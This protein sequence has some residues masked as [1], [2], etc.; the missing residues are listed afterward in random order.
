ME[1]ILRVYGYNNV[2]TPEKIRT[3]VST[4]DKWS[5][6]KLENI[7]AGFL[8]ANGISESMSNSLTK[9]EYGELSGSLKR[10]QEVRILNALSGDLS[11]MR[12]SMA[13]GLLESVAYNLNRKSNS[14][15]FFELGNTYHKYSS[16]YN[17]QKHLSI[18]LT[19]NHSREYWGL[20]ERPAG[21]FYLKGI[22]KSLL[23]RLG[24]V[25]LV[26]GKAK[27]DLFSEGM[28]WSSGKTKLVEF[29]VL[30]SSLLKE[31]G[32]KQEVL[33]A[34]LDWSRVM[35][36]TGRKTLSIADL[37]K[38]PEVRRDLA[39]LIDEQV[40]FVDL[41]DFALQ[42]ERKLL[43]EVDLFDVY[44]GDKL[45]AGK[46]SYALSFILQDTNRTLEDKQIEK[47]MARLQEGFRQKF[48]AEIR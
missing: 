10:E 3:S 40:N 30:K 5:V 12:Q 34:D 9:P 22:L 17:E 44:T 47:V 20:N 28:A 36:H 48:G 38:Y 42:T 43:K 37:P 2:E 41:H 13:F 31:F 1:E 23:E 15:K 4:S 6:E 24:I 29:G 25:E 26:Y 32:I 27:S 8:T 45:P 16:G 11:L 14:L 46:K 35:E 39:L 18:V 21:M 19:G 7:A 33:F